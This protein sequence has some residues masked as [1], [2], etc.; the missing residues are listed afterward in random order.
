MVALNREKKEP[1]PVVTAVYNVCA[2]RA[3]REPRRRYLGMSAIGGPCGRRLWLDFHGAEKALIEGRTARIFENG[4]AVEARVI[5]NLRLAG[6]EIDGTQTEYSD[7]AGQ[8][9]GHCDGVI[10]GV[11]KR[12]H[13]LEIKGLNR[14]NFEKVQARGIMAKLEH[15]AQV[16]CYMGYADLE[17]ALYVVEN[18]DTQ[19]LYAERVY[20]H[21]ETF[22]KLK[23]RAHRILTAQVPPPKTAEISACWF[24]PF[25]FN[26]ENPVLPRKTCRNCRHHRPREASPRE[27][28]ANVYLLSG[29]I[30]EF[31]NRKDLSVTLGDLEKI[32][33]D[34]SAARPD[35]AVPAEVIHRGHEKAE[36]LLYAVLDFYAGH[37]LV[38]DP[39]NERGEVVYSSPRMEIAFHRQ[40]PDLTVARWTYPPAE[41]DWCAH[42]KHRV[43]LKTDSGC[44]DHE[45]A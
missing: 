24:C 31:R 23:A 34:V 14:G 19:E 30:Q 10:H 21:Q 8:F 2:D 40:A 36:D 41:K 44:S 42:P 5:E 45:E 29:R 13:I 16:Q 39:D 12:P 4:H 7:F 37:A 38:E 43:P 17:R 28:A 22:L 33:A 11:T 35:L 18:K 20:F 15:Y 26:C 27:M 3:N 9:K 32:V 1:S 25:K 6:Y